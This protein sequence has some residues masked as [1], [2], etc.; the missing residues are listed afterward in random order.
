MIEALQTHRPTP[1]PAPGAPTVPPAR[2]A[3][4]W[5][6]AVALEGVLLGQLLETAGVGALPVAGSDGDAPAGGDQFDT[7]LRRHQAEALAESGATGLAKAIYRS[8]AP[9]GGVA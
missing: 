9:P 3:A 2:D 5:R 6:Q 1:G 8:L 4:L 7:F